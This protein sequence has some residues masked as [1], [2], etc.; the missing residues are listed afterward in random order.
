M[1]SYWS[2]KVRNEDTY[3]K[4]GV[5]SVVDKMIEERLRRFGHMKM[6]FLDAPRRR[7]QRLVIQG[8]KRYRQAE[9][10]LEKDDNTGYDLALSYQEPN[11]K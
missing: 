4:E 8:T 11:P 10:V 5:A 1:W 9:K 7:Y 2:D 6:M 3:N